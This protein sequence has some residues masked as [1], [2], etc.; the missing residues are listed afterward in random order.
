VLP[1]AAFLVLTGI[2]GWQPLAEM[3]PLVYTVK[4]AVVGGLWWY[5]RKRYPLP[6]ADGLLLGFIVGVAGVVVWIFLSELQLEKALLPEWLTPGRRT[7]FDPFTQF[8]SPAGRWAF[9]AV[10][11]AG[12]AVVVPL[13]EEVFWR[14]FLLR[15]IIKEEF[16]TVPIGTFSRGSFALVT[17]TFMAVHPELLAALVWGAAINGLLYRTRNL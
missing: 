5:F 4:I 7:A 16:E 9:I 12:L 8:A 14:G 11:I 17:L 3:Y 1:F 13:M 2:E 15:W 6:R 10:R